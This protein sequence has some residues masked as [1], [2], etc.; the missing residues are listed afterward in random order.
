MI[1]DFG[2]DCKENGYFKK[3]KLGLLEEIKMCYNISDIKGQV[4]QPVKMKGF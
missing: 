3:D 1:H 4:K 2:W